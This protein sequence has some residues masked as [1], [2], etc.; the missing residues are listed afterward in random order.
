MGEKLWSFLG[1]VAAG[2]AIA[3]ATEKKEKCTTTSKGEK[4]VFGFTKKSE[5]EMDR[6]HQAQERMMERHR[7]RYGHN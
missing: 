7:K 5:S 3:K 4:D 6:A 2:I 1:G